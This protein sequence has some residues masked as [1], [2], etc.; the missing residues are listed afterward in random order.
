MDRRRTRRSAAGV[1]S[2]RVELSSCP[3]PGKRAAPH[4]PP[5]RLRCA[6][7]TRRAKP[8]DLALLA[9]M[10]L[11][12]SAVAARFFDPGYPSAWDGGAHFVRLRAMTELFLP[13][14]RTDGWCWW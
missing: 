6:T 9:A 1:P 12:A 14:G 5:T 7:V 11:A 8:L 13:H 3:V 4:S 10:S 2:R